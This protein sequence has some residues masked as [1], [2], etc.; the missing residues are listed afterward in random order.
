MKLYQLVRDV[1]GQTKWECLVFTADE[2]AA[3]FAAR[4]YSQTGAQG[5]VHL[6]EEIRGEP[7]Y[8]GLFGP[9]WGGF[10]DDIP[11][12]RYESYAVADLLST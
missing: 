2:V 8:A 1:P 10:I 9:I 6:R 11:T 7:T 3:A 4:G 5:G 12:V